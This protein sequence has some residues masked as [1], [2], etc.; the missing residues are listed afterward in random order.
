MNRRP[1]CYCR[2]IPQT[3]RIYGWTLRAE[4]KCTSV[5]RRQDQRCSAGGEQRDPGV[6]VFI[7][8]AP[9]PCQNRVLSRAKRPAPSSCQRY[10]S[11]DAPLHSTISTAVENDNTSTITIALLEDWSASRSFSP[12]SHLRSNSLW[13][14]YTSADYQRRSPSIGR[15]VKRNPSPPVPGLC[16]VIGRCFECSGQPTPYRAGHFCRRHMID[17]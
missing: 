2:C 12:H 16:R 6:R 1:H 4:G 5:W 7:P 8:D 13:S 10:G 3:R 9:S 15:K 17:P 11:T 14:K